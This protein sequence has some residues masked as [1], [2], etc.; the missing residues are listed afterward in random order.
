MTP[1]H[2]RLFTEPAM[3]GRP[4]L[5]AGMILV[6]LGRARI[7]C[8]V[9]VWRVRPLWFAVPREPEASPARNGSEAD[10]PGRL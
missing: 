2:F 1:K 9:S 6:E 4:K 8:R 7:R 10:S 3:V 5:H